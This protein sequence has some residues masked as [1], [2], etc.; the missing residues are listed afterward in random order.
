MAA[1]KAKTPDQADVSASIPEIVI[2]PDGPMVRVVRIA[3]EDERPSPDAK[4]SVEEF[5]PL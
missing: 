1:R 5:R 2:T 4:A 3:N